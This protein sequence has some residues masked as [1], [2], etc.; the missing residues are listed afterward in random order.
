MKTKWW[1][2][3]TDWL[4]EL[5]AVLL[6]G[7]VMAGVLTVGGVAGAFGDSLPVELPASAVSG[8]VDSGLRA[9]ATVLSEQAVTV[10]V[11]DPSA[12]QRALWLASAAPTNLVVVLLLI[13]LL[14]IVRH[15]RR[16]DPFTTATVRRLRVLAV[17]A[18]AGGY[19]AAFAQVLAAMELSGT[20]LS[21]GLTAYFELPLYWFVV[22]FGLFA[23]AEVVRRGCALRAELETVI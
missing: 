13:Q 2:A 12:T 6:L 19:L 23:V 7:L 5:Q 9:G 4:Q 10:T 21:D 1:R 8:S 14:R 22:G 18:L 17:V 3:K 16:H 15:A 11:A 20:V